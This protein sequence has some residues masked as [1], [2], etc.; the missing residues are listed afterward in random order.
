[1]VLTSYTERTI[2]SFD[3]LRQVLDSVRRSGFCIVDQELELGLRSLAVPVK[4]PNGRVVAALNVG[5]HAQR[6]PIQKL[7]SEFLPNIRAAAQELSMLLR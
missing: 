1:V 5:T 4:S 2:T 7:Q 3:K 6:A